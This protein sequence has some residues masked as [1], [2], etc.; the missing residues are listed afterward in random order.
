[1]LKVSL[2]RISS[3][4][5]TGPIPVSTTSADTCPD[6]CGMKKQPTI[7][8]SGGCYAESGPLGMHWRLVTAGQRGDT[9][10]AF[11]AQIKAL[12]A[13]T[14]WR[15][16][17]AGD[18]PGTNNLVDVDKLSMLVRASKRLKGF[19][20]THKPMEGL[21][22]E[23]VKDANSQGFTIN[24]SADTMTQADALANKGL[25]T[26]V[27]LPADAPR[28]LKTP[29]GKTVAI[30]PAQLS[31]KVQCATCQLCAK[32]DRNFIIGFRAHGASYKKAQKASMEDMARQALVRQAVQAAHSN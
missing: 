8:G 19:T 1:M 11:C 5:K 15:H 28:G 21:N 6:A 26:V 30:C 25:P 7:T 23:A 10:E 17:Q 14:F 13:G 27:V 18:L 20:Y 3:N 32:A 9:W 12:P 22:L 16:N 4:V 2:T 31:D 29:E 24:A